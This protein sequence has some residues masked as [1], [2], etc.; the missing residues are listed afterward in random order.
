MCVCCPKGK[1][2]IRS[3]NITSCGSRQEWWPFRPAR[4]P[5]VFACETA[6]EDRLKAATRDFNLVFTALWACGT[7]GDHVRQQGKDDTEA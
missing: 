5:D 7:F 4:D 1:S 6:T 2:F 3:A